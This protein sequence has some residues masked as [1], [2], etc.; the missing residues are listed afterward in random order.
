M[1]PYRTNRT[2]AHIRHHRKRVMAQRGWIYKHDGSFAKGKIH[3][4]CWWCCEKSHR[5]G[6]PESE[7]ARM[8][9]CEQQLLDLG[10]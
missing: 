3:C 9:D 8:V 4:S 7:Q 1:K 10:Y 2:Q 5:L 6:F